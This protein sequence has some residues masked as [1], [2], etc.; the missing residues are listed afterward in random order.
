M[1]SLMRMLTDMF[2]TCGAC[3]RSNQLHA[4]GAV[5]HRGAGYDRA[6]L[7]P[8]RQPLW[9]HFTLLLVWFCWWS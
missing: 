9:Q 5:R 3:A 1:G 4:G 2:M 6:S 7:E 8:C